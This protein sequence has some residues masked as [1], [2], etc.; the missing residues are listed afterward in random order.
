MRPPSCGAT[1]R[2]LAQ[3]SEQ[4]TKSRGEARS[5]SLAAERKGLRVGGSAER[6]DASSAVE[7]G[8]GGNPQDLASTARLWKAG[9]RPHGHKRPSA[10]QRDAPD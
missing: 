9:R 3:G 2:G 8:G 10:P 5:K 1:G 6:K 7:L 4:P